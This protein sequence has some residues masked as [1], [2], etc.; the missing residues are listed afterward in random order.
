MSDHNTKK[1]RKK[2]SFRRKYPKTYRLLTNSYHRK[3]EV[4]MFGLLFLFAILA[5]II[6]TDTTWNF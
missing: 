6:F 1:V 3:Q 2:K 4:I 5:L